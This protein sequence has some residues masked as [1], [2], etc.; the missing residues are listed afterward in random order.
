MIRSA[1]SSA[2]EVSQYMVSKAYEE[3]YPISNLQLQK[4]LYFVQGKA[5]VK[6]GCPAF[7]ESFEAWNYG[8]VVPEVYDQYR[9]YGA[10]PICRKYDTQLAA[11][12]VLEPLRRIVDDVLED[13]GRETAWHLVQYTHKANSPWSEAIRDGKKVISKEDMKKYFSSNKT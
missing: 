4:L 9:V 11:S 5:L 3:G 12:T 6:L 10:S 13:Y 7:S 1:Y 2:L 8:P